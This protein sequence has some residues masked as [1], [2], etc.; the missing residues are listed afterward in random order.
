MT[1]FRSHPVAKTDRPDP[2]PRPALSFRAVSKRYGRGV[3][4]LS[5]VTFEVAPGEIVGLIGPNGAGKSTALAVAAGLVRPTS[6]TC[7]VL[8]VDLGVARRTP[9][10]V[11]VVVEQPR[12]VRTLD[13]RSNLRMLAA[14][15]EVADPDDIDPI[16][17]EVGLSEAR[18]RRV[19]GFSL[20]MRQ[21]LGIAQALLER[22]RLL[23]VDEP[24]NGLDPVGIREI[25]ELLA[26]RAARGVAIVIASHALTELETLCDRALLIDKGRIHDEI[27]VGHEPVLIRLK[28]ADGERDLLRDLVQVVDEHEASSGTVELLIAHQP[29]ARLVKQLVT[30]G[31]EVHGVWEQHRTLEA[32]YLAHV[33]EAS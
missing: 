28:I 14:V 12:F 23:L 2:G 4:A 21:R 1:R 16:L 19:G 9:P 8:G 31:I 25:R 10:E 33:T 32:T 3:R 29:V 13:A 5:D 6:G 17:V 20:G 30:A 24:T 11:G 27:H 22:P 7:E 26:D 15:S 18:H